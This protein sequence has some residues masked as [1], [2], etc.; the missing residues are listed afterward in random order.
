MTQSGRLLAERYQ[1]GELIGRGGM[2]DVYLAKD[3]RLGRTVAVKLLRST[4]ADDPTF[5]VRFRQEAQSA[6]RM[7]HPS[8]VRVFDAGEDSSL[9][10][11]GERQSA[12]FIVM[13]YVDGS[14]LKDILSNGPLAAAEA[15]RIMTGVLTALDYSHRS[16]IV[17][18]DIKPANI[19]LT[20]AGE[21]KV[22]DF[23]I[24]RAV[25]ETSTSIS[26]TSTILGTAQYFS[27]EQAKG[28][29]V[30]ARSDLYSAGI[31]L[32]EM[33]TG[34][35]PFRGDSAVAVAYQHV[36]ELPQPP[37]AFNSEVSP[38]F[39]AVVL[40][41]LAKD[42]FDRYQSAT[43]FRDAVVGAVAGRIPPAPVADEDAATAIFG[44]ASSR[45]FG[46]DAALRQLTVEDAGTTTQT[47]PP[48]IW[49]WA[50]VAL[51]LVILVAILFWVLNLQ[52]QPISD[53]TTQVPRVAGASYEAGARNLEAAELIPLRVDQS[54]DTIAEGKIIETDPESGATVAKGETIRVYVSTGK[55]KVVLPNLAGMAEA[56]ARGAI[57][58]RGL[59]AGETTLAY[60]PTV[61][62]GIVISSSPL[63]ESEV[64]K[65]STVNLVVSSGTV[66][67]PEVRGSRLQEAL[68]LLQGPTLQ[69]KPQAQA[70]PSC[71][72]T[73]GNLVTQQSIGPGEVPQGSEV[74]LTYCFGSATP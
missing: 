65:G 48:V 45:G 73:E 41:A 39:D 9:A 14:M 6:A 68:T 15:A 36:S 35:P 8:I 29:S 2:A 58:K 16:G 27:P 57:E 60:S 44:T 69:L 46:S 3:L 49:I 24:A 34:R 25:S 52:P 70:D 71:P 42:R 22:M 47:R 11:G 74:I 31:V 5:R 19:M 67:M 18:R 38:A 63:S 13:E 32:Y 66:D 53:N 51:V 30:D 26:E 12:P 37:S 43:E 62:K 21:I 4:F 20:S 72:A 10:E 33:L 23:G 61:A 59:I 40:R 17:H 1:L 64:A 28:E 56:D 55:V 54:S 7:T 50:G